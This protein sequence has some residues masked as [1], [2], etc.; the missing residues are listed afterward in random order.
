MTVAL[1]DHDLVD[2]AREG[3]GVPRD[4]DLR[5]TP[6]RYAT[7]APLEELCFE[8][9]DGEVRL[10]LKDLNRD[11]LLGNAAAKPEFLHEPAREIETYRRIL[12]PAG[13]GPRFVAAETGVDGWLLIEKVPGVELWQVG[14][15]EVW[16]EVA[17][18]TGR[19]HAC[20]SGSL[21]ELRTVNPLLLEHDL[22]W[23]ES[24][25]ERAQRALSDSSDP[26]VAQ[27]LPALDG[28]GEVAAHLAS[29]HRTLIH[30]ELYP[31]NVL[32]VRSDE[33]P[34]RVAPVDWEMAA[35]GPGVV[36]LAALSGGWAPGERDRLVAAYRDGLGSASEHGLL[37]DLDRG[38]LHLALQW[39]GWSPHWNPPPEH[40]HDWVDEALDMTERLGLR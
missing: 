18:W 34:T 8:T 11:R 37:Q 23:Y 32:V 9:A 14:E 36:D 33:A 40:A 3:C 10:I 26:R 20:F 25:C 38:R 27:L 5:R 29:S 2:L 7:S 39:L 35:L 13:I 30:G 19:L 24:W 28:Y 16:E 1:S 4:S 22:A 12:A 15:L 21:N 17:A 6:Y 31:A